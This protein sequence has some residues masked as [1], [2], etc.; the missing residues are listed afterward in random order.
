MSSV[1]YSSLPSVVELRA[2]RARDEFR[3][4]KMGELPPSNLFRT[5]CVFPSE[6]LL[7]V[8]LT[9]VIARLLPTVLSR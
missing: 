2:V 6:R 9:R 7:L 8:H 4:K 1:N 3:W 5:L